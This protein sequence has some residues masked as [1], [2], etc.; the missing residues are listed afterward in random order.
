MASTT[1]PAINPSSNDGTLVNGIVVDRQGYGSGDLTLTWAA[2][3]GTPSAAVASIKL[4]SNTASSTSSPTPVLFDTFETALDISAAGVKTWAFD[5]TLASRYIFVAVAITFTDGT[6]PESIISATFELESATIIDG[7]TTLAA[8]KLEAGISAADTTRDELLEALITSAS[9][10]IRVYLDREIVRTT[11]TDELYAVNACQY[12]Y[13]R[14]YPIQSVSALTL[15]GAT[16]TLNVDYFMAPPD[17]AAGRV[18]KPS[19]WTGLFYS[20]GTFPEV[21]AGARGVKVTYTAGWYLP[22]DP[23]YVAGSSDSLPLAISYA[24]NRI[25]VSRFRTILN[26]ADGVQQYSEGGISTTWFGP[27]SFNASSGGFDA[28]AASML[29]PYKRREAV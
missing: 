12:L 21:Y 20:R 22:A 2:P 16:Q 8:V 13:F 19:G 23:L 24:C 29:N 3:T 4:Y 11:H 7:L 5:L 28:V 18:Y 14:E 6:S 26:N 27:E 1:F 25:V 9:A 15:D 17:A 10:A